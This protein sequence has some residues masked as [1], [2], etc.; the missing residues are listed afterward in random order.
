MNC[1]TFLKVGKNKCLQKN[2]A[3]AYQNSLGAAER[4]DGFLLESAS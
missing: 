3:N 1:R 2:A 4:I